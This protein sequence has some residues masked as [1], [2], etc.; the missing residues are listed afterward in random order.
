MPLRLLLLNYDIPY[1]ILSSFYQQ[2]WHNAAEG[3]N[4]IKYVNSY[5]MNCTMNIFEALNCYGGCLVGFKDILCKI[6][7][8]FYSPEFHPGT[9]RFDKDL[10]FYT[11][12]CIS[13]RLC[14]LESE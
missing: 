1:N 5:L 7:Q 8:P 13:L 6:Q 3:E 14:P 4:C 9:L 2:K 11:L 10:I 12:Q